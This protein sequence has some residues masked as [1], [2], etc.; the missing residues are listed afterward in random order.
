MRLR[1]DCICL[2]HA[3]TSDRLRLR[4]QERNGLPRRGSPRGRGRLP[5]FA[6]GYDVASDIRRRNGHF[7]Q[8]PMIWLGCARKERRTGE[9]ETTVEQAVDRAKVAEQIGV[10]AVYSPT[11]LL[12]NCSI[13]K[14][15]SGRAF[16]MEPGGIEPPSRDRNVAASTRVVDALISAGRRPS[17]ASAPPSPGEV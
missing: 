12:L 16:S 9:Q 5:V 6:C 15:R 8:Y 2:P 3:P 10:S 17:T 11:F 14:A 4:L 13:E 7:G 1:C